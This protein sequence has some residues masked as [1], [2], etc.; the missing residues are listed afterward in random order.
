MDVRLVE[1]MA[2]SGGLKEPVFRLDPTLEH[3]SLAWS[4]EDESL[5]LVD[6][7]LDYAS[8]P[9]QLYQN[10][11]IFKKTFLTYNGKDCET[12]KMLETVLIESSPEQDANF[13]PGF[14]N[15]NQWIYKPSSFTYHPGILNLTNIADYATMPYDYS[16]GFTVV[17]QFLTSGGSIVPNSQSPF[18]AFYRAPTLTSFLPSNVENNKI[19]TD[20]WYTS[21]VIA[22]KTYT[23]IGS[24]VATG[25]IIYYP[26]QRKFYKNLTGSKGSES[27]DPLNPTLNILSADW[28]VD[29]Q[30]TD[31]IEFLRANSQGSSIGEKVYYLE[32]Q[33]LVTVELNTAILTELKCQCS[34]CDKPDFNTSN[35]L[36]YMKLMQKRLGSYVLFNEENFHEAQCVIES[37]RKICETS[38]C[39]QKCC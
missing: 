31:W 14:T 13:L 35:I 10:N 12:G 39:N 16:Q 38:L 29:V 3:V 2:T 18:T 21:Y 17:K 1:S 32:T 22:C 15:S 30:F 20:G 8:L 28:S 19:Y 27:Q 26:P 24:T 25:D 6:Y 23:S 34:C 5:V 4:A 36:L 7:N 9:E 33:H 11:G 37:S